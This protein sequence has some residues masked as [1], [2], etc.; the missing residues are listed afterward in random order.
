MA[1][2]GFWPV[3]S[4]LKDVINY[5]ENPDKTIDKRFLDDDLWTAI[6]YAENERK[7]DQKMYVSA[8]NCPK[9]RAYQCMMDTKRRF[10]KLGGNVAYHGYQSFVT[11]EVTPEE[12]HQIGL[13]TAR[14]MWGEEYEIVVTT[15]LNTDNIHNHIIINSVSFKSGRKFENHICDHI[16]LREISDEVC[17]EHGKSVIPFRHFYGNKKAHWIHQ[18]GQ[19]THR[20]IL[21]K[22]VDKA[23]SKCSTFQALERYLKGLGYR[24]ERDF[25]YQ[26]PSVKAEGWKRSV[27]LESLGEEYSKDSIRQKMIENQRKPELYA[28]I[29]P[30]RKRK[31]LL[32][33]EYNLHRA[34]RMD[35][36]TLLFQIFVE[37][38][39]LCTGNIPDQHNNRPLSPA[40]RAEVRKL[41]RYLEEY[42]LLCDNAIESP[43][44]FAKWREGLDS[45]IAALEQERYSLRC[46]LRRVKSPEEE[47]ALKDQCKAITKKITPLRK[48]KKIA[49]RIEEHIPKIRELMEQERQMESGEERKRDS[50]DRQSR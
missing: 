39:Q 12:A 35:S 38:L 15:H 41:D 27:R 36:V 28:I 42:R 16:R 34:E 14:R 20:D 37:L 9:Q 11:G 7:T 45:D 4:R 5:A 48:Q 23:I 17:R 8:I 46:K 40:M 26:Y 43:Q 30:S 13:E 1:S 31:P 2:T 21:R 32:E 50:K 25:R 22:D 47:T 3:K 10:G 33:L 24:F 18:S 6:N 19:L 29:I 44:D 49:T